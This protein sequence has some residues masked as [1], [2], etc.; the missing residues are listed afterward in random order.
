MPFWLLRLGRTLAPNDKARARILK[1]L[2]GAMMI[3]T[4]KVVAALE[5]LGVPAGWALQ[6]VTWVVPAVG[7]LLEQFDVSAVDDQVQG[8]R[9]EGYAEGYT[10]ALR[11][12]QKGNSR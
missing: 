2:R 8:A 4:P 7:F 12:G 3:A 9:Q 5:A 1:A 6:A 11:E 10:A